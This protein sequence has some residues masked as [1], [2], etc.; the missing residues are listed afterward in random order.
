MAASFLN[1]G[2]YSLLGF[3]IIESNDAFSWKI[4]DSS[5]CLVL[6]SLPF[7]DSLLYLWG[8]LLKLY[9]LL[10]Y[11]EHGVNILFH[12]LLKFLLFLF[13]ALLFLVIRFLQILSFKLLNFIPELYIFL[14]NLL[15]FL[16]HAQVVFEIIDNVNFIDGQIRRSRV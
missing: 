9:D 1:F 4:A 10:L 5:G 7:G 12:L 6:Q 8:N 14:S 15:S 3:A 16:H 11:F 2:K 13:Q